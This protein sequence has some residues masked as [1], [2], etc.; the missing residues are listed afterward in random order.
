MIG[1]GLSLIGGA[2][3]GAALMYLFDPE[4]GERRRA[5][6]GETASGALQGA[7]ERFSGTWQDLAHRAGDLSEQLKAHAAGLADSASDAA[8]QATDSATSMGQSLLDRARRLG[9][10]IADTASDYASRAGSATSAASGYAS[11]ARSRA[12]DVADDY[13]SRAADY[14][15]SARSQLRRLTGAAEDYTDQGPSAGAI[16]GYSI[17]AVGA[18]AL[19]AAAWY[20]L[21]PQH[22]RERRDMVSEKLSGVLDQTGGAFRSTGQYLRDQFN[23]LT[24]E[25]KDRMGSNRPEGNEFEAGNP[26]T[27]RQ[28][29]G[30]SG[31]METMS[32]S[33]HDLTSSMQNLDWNTTSRVAIGVAGGALG[34]YGAVRHDWVGMGVGVLGL[35]MIAAGVYN[36]DFSRMSEQ[37]SGLGQQIGEQAGNFSGMVGDTMGRL[38]DR[39]SASPVAVHKSLEINA[40]VE[41]V[42]EFWSNYENFP[43]IM[44]NVIDVQDLGGGGSRWRVK[45]PAGVPVQWNARLTGHV[46]NEMISWQ[47]EPGST[48]ENRG[49]VRF[50]PIGDGR[51]RVD[52]D[53]SYTPPAG[54]LGHAVARLFGADPDSEMD[55]DLGKVKSR[56][57]G[58]EQN[59]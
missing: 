31:F 9:Q 53:L 33:M 39:F 46:S 17:S 51:T 32:S 59:A 47:S 21:D 22:G 10:A 45:G 35:G 57:E 18:L 58:Q 2:G 50:Q 54:T 23:S 26:E 8:G 27:Y 14:V 4:Q 48:V 3:L 56:L 16:A 28:A 44:S 12:A 29:A 20:L 43:S 13:R 37:M 52:I 15:S 40:P 5:Q 42:F 36:Y 19:G 49:T 1:S 24:S 55:E 30:G 11:D 6:L 25:L 38:G 7:A 41:R 34:F